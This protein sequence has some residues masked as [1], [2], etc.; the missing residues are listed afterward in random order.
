M[1]GDPFPV[2]FINNYR[3]FESWN[4]VDKVRNQSNRKLR[5]DR[6]VCGLTADTFL[7]ITFR[8]LNSQDLPDLG[9]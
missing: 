4:S 3:D 7:Q 2:T 6:S 1:R 5:S 9:L 8:E